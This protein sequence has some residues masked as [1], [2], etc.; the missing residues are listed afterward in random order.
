MLNNEL[1]EKFKKNV[2]K[3]FRDENITSKEISE[4]LK[5]QFEFYAT[6]HSKEGKTW[7]DFKKKLSDSTLKDFENMWDGFV[8]QTIDF[9]REHKDVQ[10]VIEEERQEL[11]DE[12]NP[13]LKEGDFKMVP[14]LKISFGA[15]GLDESVKEGKWT[16]GTDSGICLRIGSRNI[17]E[18]M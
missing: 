15:D 3:F 16:P 5:Q 17:I 11:I 18:M 1:R 12:W 10:D 6:D 14:D 8:Q 9:V 4:L 2:Y 7:L 13:N